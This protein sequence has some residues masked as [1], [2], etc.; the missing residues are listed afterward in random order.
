MEMVNSVRPGHR[1]L[2]VHEVDRWYTVSV[3][4]CGYIK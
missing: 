4:R 3:T 2:H 1:G